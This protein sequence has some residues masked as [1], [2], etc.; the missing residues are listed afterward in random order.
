M[1]IRRSTPFDS[2]LACTFIAPGL[3]ERLNRSPIRVTVA[4]VLQRRRSDDSADST[5][6]RQGTD[7]RFL[8]VYGRYRWVRPA[9][10]VV[11]AVTALVLHGQAEAEVVR[12]AIH[13]REPFAEGQAFGRSGPYERLAGRMT[14]AVDPDSPANQRIAD[15]QLAPRNDQG[16]VECQTDFFLLMPA[17]PQRGNGAI[18][19]DVNNRGN[20]LAM[21]TFNGARSNDPKTL[22][23][24]GNGF[25]MQHG[26]SVLWCGWNGEVIEDGTD[27]L[28]IDLPVAVDP[29]GEP[30][31]GPAHLEICTTEQV[32]S[33]PF[34]WSP[35]GISDAYPTASL[36]Q[37]QA[38]LVIRPHREADGVELP[39]S[40]WAFARRDEDGRLIPDGQH[41][42]V[43]GGFRPG[44]LYDLTYTAKAPRITGL[45]LAALRDCVAFFRYANADAQG[46]SNPLAGEIDRAHVF[47]IS[48]SGRVIHHFMYEG[49]NTDEQ[50]RQVFD[51]ALIHVAGAGKG[52]FNHRFR[53]TTEYGTEHEGYLSGSE[54][55]PFTLTEQTDPVTG[56]SGDTGQRARQH[57]HLPKLIFT[58]SSTEYWSRAA[59]LLHTDVEGKTDLPLPDSMR[60]YLIAGSQHLGGGPATAGMS[61]QPRNTLKHK[62]PILRA[63]LVNLDRWV[64]GQSDPPPSR[65]PRLDDHTLVD[66]ETFRARFPKIPSVELPDSYYQPFRLDFG[67]RFHSEGI[68]DIVPPRMGPRYRTLVPAVDADGNELAGIRLPDITVPLGTHTGWNLRAEPYGAAGVLSRLDGM[69]LAFAST[70]AQRLQTGDPR[71][72]LQERYPS[73]AEYVARIAQTATQLHRE[74]FLL[75]ED[76]IEILESATAR[77]R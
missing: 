46:V 22:A 3:D 62:P 28:L 41:L 9:L 54:S 12:M 48:Q 49:F 5:G 56:Q 42:S 70:K 16:R 55:F 24:A 26:Y 76:V 29:A 50:N 17:D 19:Y 44:W 60:I 69:F 38:K 65:Y 61:Q 13:S 35:W 64:R 53:M 71:A 7:M 36:Q 37:D 33:R 58:Q 68:A 73:Q 20:K 4:R 21:E 15:L 74:G 32:D 31:T 67:P 47:G 8:T 6:N 40:D 10:A 14:I 63:M 27:R 11:V 30:L 2:L 23:D 52:M 66:L 75:A 39:K 45:G 59:S 25:L 77:D 51:G 1:R 57:D 34:S 72:S 18:L 43:K